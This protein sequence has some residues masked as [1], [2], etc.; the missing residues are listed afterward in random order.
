MRTSSTIIKDETPPAPSA[1]AAATA[2]KSGCGCQSGGEG[3]GAALLSGL[4]A[5]ALLRVGARREAQR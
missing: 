3:G 1:P 4:G 5:L 2:K